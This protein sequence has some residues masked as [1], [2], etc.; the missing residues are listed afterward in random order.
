MQAWAL[1]PV[2]EH[3]EKSGVNLFSWGLIGHTWGYNASAA[4]TIRGFFEVQVICMFSHWVSGSPSAFI[5]SYRGSFPKFWN[6]I[7][8]FL[9]IH[10]LQIGRQTPACGV[11][12]HTSVWSAR[13]AMPGCVRAVH[14][15][16]TDFGGAGF[17]SETQTSLIHSP[18]CAV[19]CGSLN[20]FEPNTC[21]FVW[22]LPCKTG[23]DWTSLF[24][25]YP[26]ARLHFCIPAS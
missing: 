8:D 19:H 7:D 17:L 4:L 3:I 16:K 10:H 1:F 21:V 23:S 11:R 18:L 22:V 24:H 14:N 13:K 20:S 2:T 9:L 5:G 12:S 15:R 25:S 26:P 6:R